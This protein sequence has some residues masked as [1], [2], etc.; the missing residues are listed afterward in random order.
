MAM[1]HDRSV[2]LGRRLERWTD[3]T[4]EREF[5]ETRLTEMY[6]Q[7]Y[8]NNDWYLN[9]DSSFLQFGIIIPEI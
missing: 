3:R 8:F 5:Q 2:E 7:Q 4:R 1:H 9:T 6:Y